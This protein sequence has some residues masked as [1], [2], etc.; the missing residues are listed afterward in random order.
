MIANV[1]TIP[2]SMEDVFVVYDDKYG[3]CRYRPNHTIPRSVPCQDCNKEFYGTDA[4]IIL[5]LHQVIHH[6]GGFDN[7]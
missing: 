1:T 3:W 2:K 6:K 5:S 4:I 7:G